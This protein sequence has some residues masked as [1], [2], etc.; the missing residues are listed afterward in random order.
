ML[1]SCPP[2]SLPINKGLFVSLLDIVSLCSPNCPGTPYVD[3]T[4]LEL[5]DLPA[6]VS[7][8]L[9]LKVWA[10]TIS[11]FKLDFP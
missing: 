6:S 2:V 8:V 4:D 5:R 11:A 3:Q 1:F 9:R 7:Q 10:T